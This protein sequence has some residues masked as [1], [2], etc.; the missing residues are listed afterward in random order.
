MTSFLAHR[1]G[2]V[3]SVAGLIVSIWVLVVAR[4]ARQA[5]EDARS[6]ARLKSLAE[7]LDEASAKIVQVAVS[8]RDRKWDVVQLLAL[9][10]SGNCKLA[11][12]R[13]GDYL[14]NRARS[15]LRTVTT[16]LRTS[17]DLATESSLRSVENEEIRQALLAARDAVELIKG[18]LGAARKAEERNEGRS[19]ARG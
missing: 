2:D 7:F 19:Y 8:L 14:P 16:I 18:V 5:A 11:S 15:D 17:V 4:K 6:A 10:V 12:Q 9:E 3:A 1:W 13:W